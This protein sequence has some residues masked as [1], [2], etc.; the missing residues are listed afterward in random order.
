M[1][2]LELGDF[3]VT[4]RIA[5]LLT[6]VR[7]LISARSRLRAKM[8]DELHDTNIEIVSPRFMNL[9]ELASG[10]VFIPE[11][12]SATAGAMAN[13]VAPEDIVF[14]KA[15]RAENVER[16]RERLADLNDSLQAMDEKISAAESVE[17][18]DALKAEKQRMEAQL[19][20]LGKVIRRAEQQ[21]RDD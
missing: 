19:E 6:D 1:Q 7:Q 12:P 11:H 17:Q 2:I 3:S 5:G 9:R 13:R 8:L 21:R 15:E 20:R 14:D 16:M 18:K 4:Y 10:R